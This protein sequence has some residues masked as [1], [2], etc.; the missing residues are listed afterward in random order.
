MHYRCAVAGPDLCRL[1]HL[2]HL[3]MTRITHARTHAR[4]PFVI[5]NWTLAN[6]VSISKLMVARNYARSTV[7]VQFIRVCIH[8]TSLTFYDRPDL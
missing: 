8:A 3:F 5:N 1:F 6:D 7:T 2:C 4:T